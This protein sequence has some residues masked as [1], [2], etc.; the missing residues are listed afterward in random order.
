MQYRIKEVSK[1]IDAPIDTL[2]YYEK[3]G[4]ISPKIDEKI[5]IVIMMPGILIFY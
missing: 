1:L 4:V 5:I 2:R 3:I